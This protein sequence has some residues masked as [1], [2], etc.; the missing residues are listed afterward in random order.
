VLS[1][2]NET[3]VRKPLEE[4]VSTSEEGLNR[5]LEKIA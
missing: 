5:R 1:I 3:Q 4:N 2:G